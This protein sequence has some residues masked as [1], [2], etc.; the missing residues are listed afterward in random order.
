M[1]LYACVLIMFS[2]HRE[3]LKINL[4]DKPHPEVVLS[5]QSS[6]KLLHARNCAALLLKVDIVKAFDSLG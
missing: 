2:P 5:Q 3:S 1:V 6:A 4:V